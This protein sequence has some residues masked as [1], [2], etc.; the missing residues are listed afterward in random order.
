MGAQSLIGHHFYVWIKQFPQF[1]TLKK[2]SMLNVTLFVWY[3][4]IFQFFY[5]LNP[6]TCQKFEY[7][8]APN[9]K[10]RSWFGQMMRYVWHQ[11][12]TG[13]GVVVKHL[14]LV[15]YPSALVRQSL[16]PDVAEK[17]PDSSEMKLKREGW[18]CWDRQYMCSI[19][20]WLALRT[21]SCWCPQ[22][23]R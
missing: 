15:Y 4:F 11:T 14:Y 12:H 20:A 3:K 17:A 16:R 2:V 9:Q 10:T 8:A 5:D 21:T 7:V 1:V 22:T 18:I 23:H 19:Y 6:P 13:W